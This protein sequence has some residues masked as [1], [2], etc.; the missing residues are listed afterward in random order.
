MDFGLLSFFSSKMN[1]SQE[2]GFAANFKEIQ[3]LDELGWDS[4]F[5]GGVPLGTLGAQLF[6]LASAISARTHQIKIGTAVHLPGLKAPGEQFEAKVPKG[7]STIERP[8]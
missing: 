6:G 5:I 3:K 2:E 1:E 4:V 8:R 7:G